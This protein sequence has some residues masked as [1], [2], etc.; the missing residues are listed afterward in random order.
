VKPVF[1][2]RE[3]AQ[4]HAVVSSRRITG[5]NLSSYR[6]AQGFAGAKHIPVVWATAT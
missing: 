5:K 3:E 4:R 6:K 1:G 2:V